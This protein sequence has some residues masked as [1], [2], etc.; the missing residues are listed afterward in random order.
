MRSQ[1][2]ALM[3]VIFICVAQSA[4]PAPP[5]RLK[6]TYHFP[7]TVGTKWVYEERFHG[8]MA[9]QWT[10]II[11][12]VKKEGAERIVSVGRVGNDEKVTLT[13]V[14]RV[15]DEKLDRLSR[16]GVKDD[17]PRRL[18]ERK[19][20]DLNLQPRRQ[21]PRLKLIWAP[22]TVLLTVPAGTYPA[23]VLESGQEL[24]KES[25]FG[26]VVPLREVSWYAPGIGLVKRAS[27]PRGLPLRRPRQ[28]VP[29]ILEVVLKSFTPGKE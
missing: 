26:L 21:P 11:T 22:Q 27:L 28:D 8:E 16:D 18:F 15:S 3:A 9:Q 20:A 6:P 25:Q 5:P 19:L 12:E 7:T 2:T 10:E 4:E 1:L 23:C 29:P 13:E 17:P 24:M 14:Y